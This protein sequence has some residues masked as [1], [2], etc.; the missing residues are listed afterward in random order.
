MESLDVNTTSFKNIGH[1]IIQFGGYLGRKILLSLILTVIAVA[2]FTICPTKCIAKVMVYGYT[3]KV[4]YMPGETVTLKIWVYNQGPDKIVLE[5]VTVE[6]P[7][8][9]PVW[10]GNYTEKSINK[11]L[12]KGENWNKTY[13][14]IIPTDSRAFL[15]QKFTV[16]AIYTIG[17]D[18]YEA[19]GDIP[20]EVVKP[21]H[22]SI[23]NMD[24]LLTLVTVQTV[25]VIVCTIILAATIFLSVRRP[26]VVLES[27]P[28]KTE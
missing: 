6:C 21:D 14:F 11:P 2:A 26:K 24:K 23:E 12:S 16:K 28:E 8:Y 5:N 15:K 22:F 7:W 13:T 17:S 19:P 9:N 27:E 10:G 3:E 20:L 25:L 18:V 4:Q 1:Y